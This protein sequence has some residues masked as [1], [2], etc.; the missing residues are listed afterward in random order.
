MDSATPQEK[1]K[2][3]FLMVGD[4]SADRNVARMI[5]TLRETAPDLE[6]W[7]CGGSKMAAQGVEILHNCEEF[8]T[9]GVV[10]I[11][12]RAKFFIDLE[13]QIVASILE[14][15][16]DAVLLVDFGTF[17]LK[18]ATALRKANL[19]M[20]I[21]YFTSPQVWG[22]RPWRIKTIAKT[23]S[24]M[25]V[26]FPFEV[27]IYKKNAVPVRFVGHPLLKNMPAQGDM[28]PRESFCARYKIDP[29][30]PL[31]GVFA[32]SRKREVGFFAPISLKA[33]KELLA[34]NPEF[35][36][37]Y[38]A[39][40]ET[41][42]LKTIAEI[43]AFGL[44]ELLE[45]N[46]FLVAHED[47]LNLISASDLVWAK[48][49][50]TTLEV[51]LFGK[52][53][54]IFYKGSWWEYALYSVLKTINYVGMPNILAGER[55]VPELLQLDCRAEQ[56]VKYTSDMMNVPALRAEI[57]RKLLQLRDQLGQGDYTA[58]LV[59]EILAVI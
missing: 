38:S 32:G 58:S 31:I 3:L 20:P 39:A 7:G 57:S 25:L 13:K 42:R 19:K 22:S 52:P 34:D 44:N 6:L 40:H 26:I 9:I 27:A 54:L 8:T 35:Q 33:I 49:G 2:S 55:I 16:P 56:L 28:L 51:T 10:E 5:A 21:L 11:V 18:L 37:A 46:L 17:N 47:N 48:S 59:E 12:K 29:Q 15:K 24:K 1:R 50:T 53:M 30:R 36:F 45:K 43:D 23:V 4:P 14:R 41:L